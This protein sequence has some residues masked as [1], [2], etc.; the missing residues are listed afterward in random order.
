M[1]FVKV[2]VKLGAEMPHPQRFRLV[3]G[4]ASVA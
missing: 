1:N 3:L 2:R 4:Y